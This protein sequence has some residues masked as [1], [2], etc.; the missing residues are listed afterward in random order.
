MLK[1]KLPLLLLILF[2]LPSVSALTITDTTFFSSVSN[3]TIFIDTITLDEAT[4]N[5]QTTQFFN[6]TSQDS[7]FFNTNATSTA[8]AEFIGLQAGLLIHNINTSTDIFTSAIGNQN[9]NAT[10]TA[11]QVIQVRDDDGFSN[12]VI[13]AQC[14]GITDG[15][16]LF[17]TLLA[18]IAITVVLV[19]V[20]GTFTGQIDI[21][22]TLMLSTLALVLVAFINILGIIMVNALCNIT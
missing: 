2:I 13:S 18:I 22:T 12:T 15:F 20:V 6:L 1:K 10:F 19:M 11:G 17:G 8:T 14:S 4:V 21:R 5:N 9:F 16:S 7:K 3:S